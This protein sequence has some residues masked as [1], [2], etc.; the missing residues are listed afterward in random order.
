M[1]VRSLRIFECMLEYGRVFAGGQKNVWIGLPCNARCH[2]RMVIERCV[3]YIGSSHVPHIDTVVNDQCTT[4]NVIH[5][6]GS[7]FHTTD[8]G[9]RMDC[10]LKCRSLFHIPHFD[11]FVSTARGQ[12]LLCWVPIARINW[13]TVRRKLLLTSIRSLQIPQL[14][15]S[16]LRHRRK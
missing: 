16:V 4:G 5:S 15:R 14:N 11:L 2:I 9:N 3:R 10:I 6:L 1:V 8:D 13:S 12:P 7:P